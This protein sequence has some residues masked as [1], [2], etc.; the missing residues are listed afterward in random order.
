MLFKLNFEIEALFKWKDHLQINVTKS[1]VKCLKAKMVN[2]DQ[3]TNYN[4]Q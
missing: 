4:A 2:S 3:A 1:S